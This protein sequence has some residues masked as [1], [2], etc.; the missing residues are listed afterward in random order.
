MSWK[1]VFFL[2][3]FKLTQ[4]CRVVGSIQEA[5]SMESCRDFAILLLGHKNTIEFHPWISKGPI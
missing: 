4:F 2:F 5:H 3:S 1:H